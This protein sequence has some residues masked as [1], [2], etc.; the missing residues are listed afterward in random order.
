M[1][2]E[3]MKTTPHQSRD[4]QRPGRSPARAPR[5]MVATSNPLATEAGLAI[6]R[7]GGNAIDAAIAACAVL[8]ITEPHQTGIGGD[9]FVLFAPRGTDEVIAYNGSGRAPAGVNVEDVRRR[10][11]GGIGETCIEAVTIPGAIDAWFTLSADHGKLPWKEVLE[12]AIA[13]ATHGVPVGDRTAFDWQLC[14]DKIRNSPGLAEL[15]LDG[16]GQI[17]RPGHRMTFPALAHTL[18]IIAE[19]GAAGFYQGEVA[20]SMVE[21]LRTAGGAHTLDDFAAHHG[22]YVKPVS[23]TYRDYT[24]HQCPPNGQGVIALLILALISELPLDPEGPLGPWRMHALIEAGRRAFALRDRNLADPAYSGFDWDYWLQPEVLR[25]EAAAIRPDAR[26]A[27]DAL[28]EWVAHRDTT[29]VAVVDEE[30]NAVSLINSVFDSFGTGIMDR[31][32]GVVFQNRGM[33]F[34]LDPKHPNVLAPGKRPMHTIIPGMVTRG[35]RAVMPYGVMGGHFQPVG[36]ALLLSH[37]LD[38]GLDVQTAMDLPRLYPDPVERKVQME[39]GIDDA[40]R[41]HLEGLGHVLSVIEEPI[42][43]AQAI[44]IDEETGMLCGGSEPRKD[45]CAS[46]Y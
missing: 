42:G 43:G 17:H 20:R 33:S 26:L 46:G 31:N 38:Y 23:Y 30:R 9:C 6:L 41:R 5:A 10:L 34:S 35:G 2:N 15:F 14:G 12:P 13:Y 28:L 4:F 24:V 37:M 18:K 19:Q 25:R 32:T 45:G 1:G 7:K 11:P 39:R 36:H 22:E 3:I 27:D 44:W 29:Y 40:L 21:T 8:A 16:E